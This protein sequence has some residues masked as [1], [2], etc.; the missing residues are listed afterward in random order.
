MEPRS[1]ASGATLEAVGARKKKQI[2]IGL[3]SD[4]HGLLRPEA[5]LAL[6]GS[7]LILH[8]GDVG[9]PRVIEELERIAKVIAVRGNN[10]EAPWAFA[11][12]ETMRV[13]VAGADILL[14][15]DVKSL[16]IEPAD[17]GI[18]AVVS[19]HSHRPSI[20]RQ[21]GVLWVN[22]GSAGPRRFR[23]PVSVGRIIA[24]EGSPLRAEILPLD[25]QTTTSG[26]QSA[27]KRT[28]KRDDG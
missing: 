22:P 10:D 2:T 28:G 1:R 23:L 19:G 21:S 8:A 6:R 27:H 16:A 17:E 15:H 7:D 11:L 24:S 13:T 9:G 12:K 4:T 25:A 3:I 14:I 18:A 26:T 5:A 20:A